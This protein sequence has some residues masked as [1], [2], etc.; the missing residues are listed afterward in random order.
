MS[1]PRPRTLRRLAVALPAAAL[2]PLVLVACKVDV[3][4]EADHTKT[5]SYD[6]SEKVNRISVVTT[7]GKVTVTEKDIPNVKVTE[8]VYWDGDGEPATTHTVA[9]GT[10]DLR[11]KCKS[12]DGCWVTYEVQVPKG[13]ATNVE[14]DA[15]EV[16]LDG[17]SGDLDVSTGAGKIEGDNLTAKQAVARTTAGTLELA[18]ASAPT[19]VDAK[20]TAGRATV[21]VP[22]GQPYAVD[23][24]ATVGDTEVKVPS[25]DSAPHKIKVR[26]TAGQARVLTA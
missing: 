12:N 9:N 8:K 2:V 7:A 6:V 1:A 16:K 25:D 21:R 23:V 11:Y 24:D 17:L 26:T 15:G 3:D 13:T 22:G 20:T 4:V 18:F 5:S 14:T 10:V 19:N